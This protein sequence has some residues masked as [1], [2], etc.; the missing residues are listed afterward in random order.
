V[1]GVVRLGGKQAG[2]LERVG[3]LIPG[4][5]SPSP[6]TRRGSRAAGSLRARP[7]AVAAKAAVA[8]GGSTRRRTS[9]RG[10]RSIGHLTV[11][12]SHRTLSGE[13]GPEV[14]GRRLGAGNR[15]GAGGNDPRASAGDDP[16]RLRAEEQTPEGR[17]P[18]TRLRGETNP[19]DR[20][21]S[22]PSRA[23]GTPR[24]DRSRRRGRFLRQVAPAG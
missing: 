4:Q 22:K 8:R 13:Q 9:P 6:A 5:P 3:S 7:W 23:G 16:A 10:A 14:G 17:E 19:Q 1:H 20:S 24:T 2:N 21:G 15:R 12:R 18:C 11:V